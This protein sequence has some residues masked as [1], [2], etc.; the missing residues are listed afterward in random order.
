MC[1]K[2]KEFFVCHIDSLRYKYI[3][4]ATHPNVKFWA[5]G[6]VNLFA[7][8][9]KARII[10]YFEIRDFLL[11]AIQSEFQSSI[12]IPTFTVSVMKVR[13]SKISIDERSVAFSCGVIYYSTSLQVYRQSL[14]DLLA[15]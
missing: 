1:H 15:I 5:I 13:V 9:V 4:Y 14:T 6:I 8:L 7:P 2:L 10:R 11:E 3:S 12:Q